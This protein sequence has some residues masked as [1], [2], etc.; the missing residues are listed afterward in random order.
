MKQKALRNA[1]LGSDAT[2]RRSGFIETPKG[3]VVTGARASELARYKG[4]AD[5][6]K[7]EKA[8]A[9][10]ARKQARQDRRARSAAKDARHYRKERMRCCATLSG[11]GVEHFSRNIRSIPEL[12]AVARMRTNM[13]KQYVNFSD[14]TRHGNEYQKSKDLLGLSYEC[15]IL[16]GKFYARICT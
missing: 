7:L 15:S 3:S 4:N 1:V 5:L 8:A 6:K 16:R 2:K 14:V 13:K 9:I 10:G 11:K 12:S